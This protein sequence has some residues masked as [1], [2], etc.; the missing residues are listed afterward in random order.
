[1][2]GLKFEW[3]M[4]GRLK[5]LGGRKMGWSNSRVLAPTLKHHDE[6]IDRPTIHWYGAPQH[7]FICNLDTPYI[8]TK[9][10]QIRNL[11]F[12][13]TTPTTHS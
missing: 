2:E 11:S 7:L 8:E 13:G 10:T 1:M 4:D 12:Y 6:I 3:K 5:K 9:N